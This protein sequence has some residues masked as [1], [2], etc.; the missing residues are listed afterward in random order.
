MYG[1]K[2]VEV[3]NT[4]AEGRLVLA[5][6]LGHAVEAEPDLVVDVA[7]LT[8]ACVIALGDRVTGV[9]GN[10]DDAI[11]RVLA[12][13]EPPARPMWHMPIPDEMGEKVRGNSKIA[14]LA[15]HNTERWGGASY[16]AAFLRE[17]VGDVPWVHL[18]IAG[19]SFNEKGAYGHVPPGGTGVAVATLVALAQDD[20]PRATADAES[21][22]RRRAQPRP[23]SPPAGRALLP[24]ATRL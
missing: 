22:T 9:F 5:D 14:D 1:G 18:D 4:D 24:L 10:D 17:F 11:A 7:T 6:A 20:R 16:A 8:G 13:A 19:P 23:G 2:T 15:Q 12:A 21:W 3:L